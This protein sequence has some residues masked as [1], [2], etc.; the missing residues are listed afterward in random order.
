[1]EN[2]IFCK[3]AGGEIP[4]E[5]IYEDK[6]TIAFPDIH[7]KVAGHTLLIP[8]THHQWF[9]DMPDAESDA[10]FRAAKKVAQKLKKDYKA[11]YIRVGIVGTDVPHVHVHLF[12]Q[13]IADKNPIIV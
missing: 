2:C 7:P 11:D 10:L 8:K 4:A 13:K 12:P 3:I 6:A 5:K 9:Q 1:M